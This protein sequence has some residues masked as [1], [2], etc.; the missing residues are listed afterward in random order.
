LVGLPSG[1]LVAGGLPTE[2][3]RD[4]YERLFVLDPADRL[5]QP[6]GNRVAHF[7]AHPGFGTPDLQASCEERLEEPT[8]DPLVLVGRGNPDLVHPQL[9][10]LVRVDVMYPRGE[11]DHLLAIDRDGQVV[12]GITEKLGRPPR[13][14]RLIEDVLRDPVEYRSVIGVEYPHGDRHRFLLLW[15]G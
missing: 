1:F 4:H 7:G 8:P 10:R 11:A 5:V 12:P 14:D 2:D 9:G 3:E 13:I 15:V 6:P